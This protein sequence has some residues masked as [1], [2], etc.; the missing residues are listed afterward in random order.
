MNSLRFLL[1]TDT[2]IYFF[3][4]KGQVAEFLIQTPPTEIAISTISLY[5]L[6]VGINRSRQPERAQLQLEQLLTWITVV[7]FDTSAASHAAKIRAELERI[8]LPIGTLDTL[9]AGIALSRGLILVS[10]NL[11]EFQRVPGLLVEDWY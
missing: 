6:Q 1:D 2:V 11:A 10:H 3:K 7:P 4:G 5:E 8:G 9:I